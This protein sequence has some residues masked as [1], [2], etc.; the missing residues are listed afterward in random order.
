MFGLE[1]TCSKV[2][3]NFSDQILIQALIPSKYLNSV[4]S[5]YCFHVW[6]ELNFCNQLLLCPPHNFLKKKNPQMARCL[7]CMDS[8][9][10]GAWKIKFMA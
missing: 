3:R 5:E 4:T 7:I 8:N 10:C 1:L 6:T 9:H 2:K